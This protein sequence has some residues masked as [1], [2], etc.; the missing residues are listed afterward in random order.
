MYLLRALHE[1][2]PR[3]SSSFGDG[4]RPA[5][6]DEDPNHS[7]VC[8][9]NWHGRSF[10]ALLPWL[11][12][13]TTVLAPPPLPKEAA[14]MKY[15]RDSITSPTDRLTDRPTCDTPPSPPPGSPLPPPPP[16][17]HHYFQAPKPSIV[18]PLHSTSLIQ[19]FMPNH[20]PL[21]VA[22]WAFWPVPSLGKAGHASP[23]A[24]TDR[25]TLALTPPRPPSSSSS[26]RFARSGCQRP[27]SLGGP[28]DK[29][30]VRLT[31]VGTHPL[32]LHLVSTKNRTYHDR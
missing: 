13:Y 28:P 19:W 27:S 7:E 6:P 11:R 23:M 21:A 3:P 22:F 15:L 12:Y 18:Q 26:F 4:Q 16:S 31:Q 29:A 2:R 5:V 30:G 25:P 10:G 20:T 14:A 17:V 8:T 24:L 1:G 9:L 32:P